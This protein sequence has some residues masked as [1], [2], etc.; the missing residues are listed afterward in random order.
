MLFINNIKV[1]VPVC[2]FFFFFSSRDTYLSINSAFIFRFTKTSA[3]ANHLENTLYTSRYIKE[4]HTTGNEVSSLLA[5]ILHQMK[6]ER[7]QIFST[8]PRHKEKQLCRCSTDHLA[9]VHNGKICPMKVVTM[10]LQQQNRKSL[11]LCTL[12]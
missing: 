4:A 5:I 12:L 3:H 8:I 1:Q 10:T 9:H 11:Y 7:L 2:V 6:V